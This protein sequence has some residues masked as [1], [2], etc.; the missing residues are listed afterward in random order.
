MQTASTTAASYAAQASRPSAAAVPL[1][2][3][4]AA[5]LATWGVFLWFAAALLIRWAPPV[6]FGRGT[7][8]VL[9]FAA[10]LPN[11]WLTMW[12]T[13]RLLSLRADQLVPAAALAAAAAMFCD[14]VALTW[15]TL[16]GP[17]TKDLV[18]AA[19]LLLWGVAAILVA[20]FVAAHRDGPRA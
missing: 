20:A 5:A 6:L 10:A 2:P 11:A 17:E 7:W 19:A 8:T 1:S 15:T 12:A 9:L 14:G 13:Q 18:S 16:Y 3:S 4:Q